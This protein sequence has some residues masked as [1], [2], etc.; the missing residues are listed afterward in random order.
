MQ[1]LSKIFLLSLTAL[2]SA[3]STLSVPDN[4][5]AWTG[6]FSILSQSVSSVE[7][8]SGNFR[9]AISPEKKTLII[10]GPL[11][12]S[13]ARIE[14]TSSDST[15]ETGDGIRRARSTSELLNQAV[16]VPV[17]F[18]ELQS[19]LQGSSQPSAAT[20]GWEVEITRAQNGNV[21]RIIGKGRVP[22]SGMNITITLLPKKEK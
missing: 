21:Q 8:H 13:V 18:D 9:F 5:E 15:M 10:T 20:Q 3:C 2:L 12:A 14:E 19:W 4:T 7:R 6:R 11:G 1:R 16:G 22:A 17:S